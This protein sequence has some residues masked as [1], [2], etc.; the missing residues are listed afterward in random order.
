MTIHLNVDRLI[1]DGIRIA[2]RD[3]PV[4][5]AALETELARLLTKGGLDRQTNIALRDVPA[6][7]IQL[8]G[9]N[10]PGELGRQIAQ[11]VY[12]GMKG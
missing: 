10:D 3:R 8:S 6:G 7:R 12:G 9:E 4:L 5:Q 2:Q 11:A 1:L